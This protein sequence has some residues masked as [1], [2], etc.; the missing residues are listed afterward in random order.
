MAALAAT[1]FFSFISF[2]AYS[3]SGSVEQRLEQLE[4]QLQTRNQLQSEMSLQLT[5]LQKE[6]KLLLGTIEEQHAISSVDSRVNT[7][8]QSTSNTQQGSN[9][10]ASSEDTPSTESER[11]EFESVL[12]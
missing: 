7:T 8:Q 11:K 12:H 5:E 6:V 2:S 9:S 3:Q 1:L 10:L 4:Q